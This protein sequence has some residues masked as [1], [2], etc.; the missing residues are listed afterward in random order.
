MSIDPTLLARLTAQHEGAL[1]AF[2]RLHAGAFVRRHESVSDLVQTVLREIVQDRDGF[3]FRGEG[4]FRAWLY[5]TALRKLADRRKYLRA[6]RRDPA[7]VVPE[8]ADELDALGRSYAAMY[9]PSEQAVAREELE[10]VERAFAKLPPGHREM[11][12]LVRIAGLSFEEVGAHVGRTPEAVRAAVSRG[13]ARLSTL[14]RE[15]GV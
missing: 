6:A 15:R 12:L 4:Q 2:V 13:L 10:C 5:T 3:E 7:R 9:T 11:I 14:L 1:R 8:T